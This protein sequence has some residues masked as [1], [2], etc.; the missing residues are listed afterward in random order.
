MGCD[1][2]V[3]CFI[4]GSLWALLEAGRRVGS[5]FVGTVA[6][7]SP[8]SERGSRSGRR[9]PE[10]TGHLRQAAPPLFAAT[11]RRHEQSGRPLPA[12]EAATV[13]TSGSGSKRGRSHRS[14]DQLTSVAT[15]PAPETA[16][17]LRATEDFYASRNIYSAFRQSVPG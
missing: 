2:T 13:A 15:S 17:G 14:I 3:K 16:G 6:G 10:I 5:G 7:N 12:I 11:W 1:S 8:G 4:L 9:E